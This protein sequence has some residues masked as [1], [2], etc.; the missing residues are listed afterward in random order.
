LTSRREAGPRLL[1]AV[2]S[3]PRVGVAAAPPPG[4]GTGLIGL[5]ERV[6]LAG[7]TLDSGADEAGDFLLRATLPWSAGA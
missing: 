1:V 6:A 2:A 5:R 3:R 7:G 4:S